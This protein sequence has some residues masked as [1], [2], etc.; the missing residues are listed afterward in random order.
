MKRTQLVVLILVFLLGITAVA[1]AQPVNV[2]I[3]TG[4][5]TN[6]TT[7]SPTPYGTWYKNFRQ[8]YLFTA[9]ELEQAGGGAGPINSIAFNVQALNTCSPMT[10]FRIRIKHTTLNA[11][12]TSFEAGDYTQVWQTAEFMPVVGWNTHTFSTPFVWNGTSNVIVDI[13]TSLIPGAYTQNA[14]VFYTAT[15][16][17]NTCLRFHS[18]TVEADTGT[19]GTTS[20]NRANA[21]FNMAPYIPSNPPNPAVL[22]GPPNGA[23]YIAVLPVLNWLQGGGSPTGYKVFLGT[24]NPPTSV[25]NGFDVGNNT[26]YTPTNQLQNNTQY[27]WKIVPYNN[28]GDAANCPVWS[29]TTVPS[30]LAVANIGTGT[31]IN[32]T[33]EA[34][35]PYG[36]YYKS[37]RQQYLYLASE[38]LDNGGAP[39]LISAIGYNVSALNTCVAM[40]NFTIRMKTTTLAALT[41]TFEVGN[42]TTVWTNANFLPAIG[43][44]THNLANPFVWDGVSNVIVE[45]VT[46][47][48]PGAYTQNASVFYTPTTGVNTCLRFQSDTVNASTGTTGTTSVNRANTRFYMQVG[49]MGSLGGTVTGTGGAPLSGANVVVVGTVYSATTN[50]SGLYH[51]PFVPAGNHQVTVSQH[52]YQDQTLP[53]VIVENQNTTL[54]FNMIQL[55]NV[56]VTGT[57][58]GSDQPTVGLA[59]ATVALTG[60]DNYSATTN[61][62]GVFTIPGVYSGHTYNY[63]INQPGY[64]PATGTVQVGTTNVNMGTL[65]LSELAFPPLNVQAVQAQN[66]TVVNVTWLPPDPTAVD[67]SEGFEEGFLPTDWTQVI[68]NTGPVGTMGVYPTWCRFETVALTPPVPPH[69][70][71]WQAGLWWDYAHQDEWLITPEF[72]CPPSASLTFWSYVYLGST[73]QDHYYIKVSTDGGQNWT[74]LWDASALTGGWNHYATP[75]VVDLSAYSGQQIK[76]AWHAIDG[77]SNDGLWY[78]WFIDDVFIGSPDATVRFPLEAM[79]SR[80]ASATPRFVTGYNPDIPKVNSRAKASN[81]D[82]LESALNIPTHRDVPRVLTGYKVWRLQQGQEQNETTWTLLTA[83][84]ITATAHTDNGWAQVPDGTYKWAVKAVYTGNVLSIPALSGPI[85]K[86]TQ[87]GTIAGIVR[88]P[89]QQPIVGAT[90]ATGIHTATTNNSGAYSMQVPAGT[91]TVT[92]NAPGYMTGTQTGIIVVTGQTTTVNFVLQVSSQVVVLQENFEATTFPPTGWNHYITNTGP[93]GTSGVLPTWCRVGTVAMTPPI[94]PPEGTWHAG[95]WWDH[96]HQDE[97]LITPQFAC[98]TQANLTFKTYVYRGSVNQDHY[99]VKVSTNNGQTWTMLWDATALTG[100]WTTYTDVLTIPLTA[101]AGQNIKLAWHAVDG[102]GNDGLWYVWFIDQVKVEGV[103]S[104]EDVT[105]PVIQTELQG[106]YPNPF[107]PETTIRYSVKEAT[108]VT[109][110][111]YNVKGQLVRTLVNEAKASGSY[112]NVWNGMDNNGHSVS[113]GVYFYKMKAGSY[114]STKKMILMK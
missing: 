6:T 69:G 94:V 50:A 28:F 31:A 99:Y 17:V 110:E 53:A 105:S 70:G 86:I 37:F 65:T 64:Q 11:L 107:N 32:G 91:Y 34:P 39:G 71:S 92:A 2:T 77:P 83:Q 5:T 30:G 109:I 76:L 24:D 7:G 74:M 85:T 10:N 18:D 98:P 63:V 29:F 114:S 26:T 4:T 16:G 12:T 100:G 40:P 43:W 42:Y 3:G 106:N 72:G 84:T 73:N 44:N 79:T 75:I 35:T 19:T 93:A 103:V 56:T 68:T 25:L 48:I 104:N 108:P 97:W 9:M 8:Q 87:I 27:Y 45:I 111:I 113:S 90:I 62:A 88:N 36:T 80:S 41:T 95:I 47:L 81:P 66:N 20:V 78:V 55:T 33:L 52:G 59:G 13:L 60:Y 14:S 82:I 101:Y 102:P 89:Q 96:E 58:V 49:G 15:T 112:S 1:W 46:D 61:A 51:F 21:V 57:V 38:I 22:V 23:E 54:N 67:I